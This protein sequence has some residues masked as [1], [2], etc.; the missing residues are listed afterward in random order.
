MRIGNLLIFL[1]EI[2]AIIESCDIVKEQNI[3]NEIIFICSDSQ[4]A[5]KAISS[6]EFKS[7][8]A[9]ECWHKL[10][11]VASSNRVDLLWALQERVIGI[12]HSNTQT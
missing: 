2:R 1:A 9:L 10:N 11:S 3:V 4:A 7:A 12:P 8:I 5:L 6:V